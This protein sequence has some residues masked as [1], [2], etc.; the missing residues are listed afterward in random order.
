MRVECKSKFSLRVRSTIR[1]TL[2]LFL[3]CQCYNVSWELDRG[4]PNVAR[5]KCWRQP[6]D[7]CGWEV[8]ALEGL[9]AWTRV[10]VGGRMKHWY[11]LYPRL[12]RYFLL[13][14]AGV[15]VPSYRLEMDMHVL[16]RCFVWWRGF[17]QCVVSAVRLKVCRAV[18][19]CLFEHYWCVVKSPYA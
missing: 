10:Y 13:Q 19:V 2:Q 11:S 17:L 16:M 1:T 12:V 18:E 9:H 7:W 5:T 6:R 15:V 4:S 3:Q 8:K 14:R